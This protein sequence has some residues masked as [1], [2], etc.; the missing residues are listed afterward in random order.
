MYNSNQELYSA[1]N[2]IKNK[3]KSLG[4]NEI[5][6]DLEKAMFAS[7]M[8]SEILGELR[9]VAEKNINNKNIPFDIKEV[10]KNVKE[11]I[12]VAMPK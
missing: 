2:L 10:L 8:A 6:N 7:S 5:A 11:S 1:V 12:D 9:I 3:L 4:L